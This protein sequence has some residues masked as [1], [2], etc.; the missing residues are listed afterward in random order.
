MG[1][2]IGSLDALPRLDWSNLDVNDPR[3]IQNQIMDGLDD[4]KLE[5]KDEKVDHFV[6][7]YY[8]VQAVLIVTGKRI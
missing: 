6:E 5:E 7:N 4:V 3:Y 8:R 1:L 2:E